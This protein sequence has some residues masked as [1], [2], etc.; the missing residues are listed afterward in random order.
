MLSPLHA[1]QVK[2]PMVF[3]VTVFPP[4]LGP[5][6]S[7]IEKLLPKSTVIGTTLFASINGCLAFFRWISFFV[8]IVGV[9]ALIYFE[10]FALAN[11]KSNFPI[12]STSNSNLST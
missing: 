10:N 5:V 2:S 4:V 11:I 3:N 12:K 6:I 1:I 8:L 9:E 7:N